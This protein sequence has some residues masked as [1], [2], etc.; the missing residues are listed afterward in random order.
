MTIVVKTALP[1]A[2]AALLASCAARDDA[3]YPI[4]LPRPA[5]KAA[6][7]PQDRPVNHSAVADPALAERLRIVRDRLAEAETT[8]TRAIAAAPA[9]KPDA[10]R[11]SEA[12]VENQVALSQLLSALS[13]VQS[14]ETDMGALKADI[15]RARV[16]GADTA[17][18]DNEAGSLARQIDALV[19]RGTSAVDSRR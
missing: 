2:F 4:L 9:P 5:E 16:D 19:A 15:A 10:A 17:A 8:L 1:L 14:V 12:W 3:A 11:G 13:A 6:T 18:L 7:T